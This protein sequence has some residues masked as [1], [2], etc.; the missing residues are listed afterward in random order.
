MKDITEQPWQCDTSESSWFYLDEAA[1]DD[2]LYT[3]HKSSATMLQA[4]A[5]IVSKNG[6]LLMN[7][8]QRADGSIDEHCEVLLADFAAWMKIYGEGPTEL[9]RSN[10]NDLKTP[11]TSKDFRFTT[12]GRTL[13]AIMCGWPVSGQAMIKSLASDSKYA[14]GEI[15]GLQL[16]G[17]DQKLEWTRTP[18]GLQI[19]LPSKR[20]CDLAY[21]FKMTL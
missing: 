19:K 15:K 20:P 5:D 10:L 16:L 11:M 9:P 3:I 8:P 12:H 4:L 21:V 18:E 17:C 2:E 6:N 14:P 1:A 13:Y 7:I